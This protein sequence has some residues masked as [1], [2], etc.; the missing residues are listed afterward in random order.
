[1]LVRRTVLRQRLSPLLRVLLP[2]QRRPRPAEALDHAPGELAAAHAELAAT[3]AELARRT[4]FTDALLET[5]EVGIVSCDAHGVINVS[6]RAERELFGLQSGLGGLHTADLEPLID[7]LHPS[8]RPLPADRYP[9]VRALRGEDLEPLDVL[10]GPVR[11]PH[12]EVVVRASRMTGPDGEVLGAVAALTDVTSERAA[13]RALV[14]ER[15]KLREAQLLGR[16]GGF[17]LDTTTGTW[18]FSDELCALWGAEPGSLTPE[19]CAE[20]VVESDRARARAVWA[21]ALTTAGRH[22]VEFRILRADDSSE[23]VI[24]AA[25]E[26]EH[27]DDGRPTR[28]R[29]S[30]L[31]MT[32]LEHAQSTARRASAF[33]DAVLAASPD[34]TVVTEV[35]EGRLLYVSPGKEILG[36]AVEDL[37][38]LGI[39]GLLALVHPDDLSELAGLYGEALHLQDGHTLQSRYRAREVDDR[40]CWLNHRVTPFRRDSEGSVVEMLAVIRDVSDLVHAEDR[41]THAALHDSLTGLPNRA[42]LVTTLEAALSRAHV[43]GQE[44]AVLFID[45]DG[46]KEVNDSGGHSAGDIVLQ[47]TALRLQHA[48]RPDDV[49]ARVG[50]DEFVIVVEPWDR[51]GTS[52][53]AAGGTSVRELAVEIARRVTEALA[54][55]VHVRGRAHHVTASIGIT[56]A[57]PPARDEPAPATV[58]EV[59]HRADAAMYRAKARGKNRY[60][61]LDDAPR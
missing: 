44:V 25:L 52:P 21:T 32:D 57:R 43:D 3:S 1:M 46:F 12:R 49:V 27:D 34:I 18:R 4:S 60:E 55:V 45:L 9:L 58:D 50:G 8:G 6:N 17:D 22:D 26:V 36:S 16:L 51:E 53:R 31:D 38:T 39:P 20:L 40:W 13:T 10:V 2:T 37:M 5:I 33:S 15:H 61:V 7:V 19:R 41:L 30:H 14:E 48:L 24:R 54:P 42:L 23:R 29:G 28:V 11:G 59:L 56:Y 35:S 47:E